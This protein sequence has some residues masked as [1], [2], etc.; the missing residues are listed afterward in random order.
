M[1][2]KSFGIFGRHFMKVLDFYMKYDKKI[3]IS[4]LKTPTQFLAGIFD[5]PLSVDVLLIESLS[6]ITLMIKTA[7][8]PSI[9]QRAKDRMW[10]L[11]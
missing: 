2:S 6:A 1:I 9:L 11:M 5:H 3:T 7:K 8:L 10:K 4:G